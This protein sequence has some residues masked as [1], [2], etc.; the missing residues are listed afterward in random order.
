VGHSA[1]SKCLVWLK[2]PLNGEESILKSDSAH[3]EQ[4]ACTK[5]ILLRFSYPSVWVVSVIIIDLEALCRS[6]RVV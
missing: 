5:V 4:Q 6:V 1:A 3:L 2:V